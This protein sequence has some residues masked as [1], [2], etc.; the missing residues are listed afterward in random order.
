MSRLPNVLHRIHRFCVSHLLYPLVLASLLACG[1][2]AGR[3]YLSHSDTYRFLVWNLFLAWIPYLCSSFIAILHQRFPR[4]GWLLIVPGALWLLFL[5]N[6]PYMVTDLWHLDWL[7]ERKPIPLWYDIAMLIS[8][9]WTGLFLAVASL[10]AMQNVVRDYCGRII[11]WL[12]VF[13]AI[14]ASSF[15]I[16]VGRFLSWN[17]WDMLLH[18]DDVISDVIARFAHPIRNP[19]AFG[20][21]FLFAAF[22]LICYLSFASIEQRQLEKIR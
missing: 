16:Y 18:P 4:V 14:G 15:G 2:F 12:F 9:A 1:I 7:G 3:A 6:A 20:F 17:S 10:N 22:M 8:F 11:G 13:G 19:G 21:T 5:P